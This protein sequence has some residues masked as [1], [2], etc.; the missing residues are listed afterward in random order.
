MNKITKEVKRTI[1]IK[2]Q[3]TGWMTDSTARGM[4]PEKK[5]AEIESEKVF[6]WSDSFDSVEVDVK[7][8]CRDLTEEELR[9]L[10]NG[11]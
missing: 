3:I 6:R 10:G 1:T 4:N 5:K 11:I 9:G 2:A 7:D 8:E